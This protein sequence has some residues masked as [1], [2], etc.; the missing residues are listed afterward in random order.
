MCVWLCGSEC[1]ASTVIMA[2]S[3]AVPS[4]PASIGSVELPPDVE[5]SVELP[6]DVECGSPVWAPTLGM[7][8]SS[9]S[10]CA[11]GL[12]DVELPEAVDSSDTDSQTPNGFDDPI[13]PDDEMVGTWRL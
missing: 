6:P 11:N 10:S 12:S 9:R 1:Q 13:D 7:A 3:D 4:L 5:W 2:N 8:E